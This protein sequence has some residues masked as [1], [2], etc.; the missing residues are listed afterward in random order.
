MSVSERERTVVAVQRWMFERVTRPLDAALP[1]PSADARWVKGGAGWSGSERL[2]VYHRAYFSR[3]VECLRD[4]YPALEHAIGGE[5][6]DELCREFIESHPPA[7]P[8]LNF[9][10]APFADFCAASRAP[11]AAFLGDLARLEWAVVEAIHAEA[12][13]ALV[14]LQLAGLSSDDWARLRLVPSP[15]C[16]LLLLSHPVHAHYEA[17]L[18][19]ETTA[20]PAR[21]PTTV[22]VCRRGDDVHRIYIEER[23]AGLLRRLL[24]SAPLAEALSAAALD[25]ADASSAADLTRAL[26]EWVSAGLFAGVRLD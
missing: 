17:F 23:L 8:S 4:D 15:A 1:E 7:S 24:D 18:E 10:G 21:A 22:V 2:A 11:G 25:A 26:S 6:F 20:P 5:A 3:L 12:P 14:G 16:R 13:P 19:G 9:Y